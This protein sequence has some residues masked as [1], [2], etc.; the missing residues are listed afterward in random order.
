MVRLPVHPSYKELPKQVDS[1][2]FVPTRQ[3]YEGKIELRG[4]PHKAAQMMYRLAA[5]PN[6]PRHF[7]LGVDSVGVLNA[8]AD[9]LSTSANEYAS[10]TKDL[11]FDAE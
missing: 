9:M 10:W 4:D 1:T 11:D 8:K 7:P 5:L 2:T 3:F 6:P